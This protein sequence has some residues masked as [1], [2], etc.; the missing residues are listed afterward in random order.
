[1]I[2]CFYTNR[3]TDILFRK[4]LILHEKKT[5]IQPMSLKMY[6]HK[7][8]LDMILRGIV[9][10]R[11]E[12]GATIDEMRSD[13]EEI[14][15]EQ[16]PLHILETKQIV[17]YLLEIDGL[18]MEKLNSGLCIWYIDDI[19]SNISD[20]D[21]DANNNVVVTIADTLSDATASSSDNGNE[22][23][24]NSY[25]IQPPCNTRRMVTSS[26]VNEH[27]VSSAETLNFNETIENGH[28]V[29]SKKRKLSISN[30][31]IGSP[32]KRLKSITSKPLPLL[33]KNLDFH[34][35]NSGANGMV[36]QITST[37][38]ENSILIHNGTNG[39]EV[40]IE[41]DALHVPERKS[42]NELVHFR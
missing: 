37:E 18:M 8:K 29:L 2:F 26:F 23:T 42:F 16:W 14:F 11:G 25:S 21:M 13:Y 41:I 36:K 17:N 30:E 9:M 15:L 39:M 1:M 27:A 7:L 24:N 3:Y 4:N 35:R 12:N 19:G 5:K 10:T 38:K 32:E 34:N 33:E 22:P 20:R 31:M 40:D 28:D 6:P